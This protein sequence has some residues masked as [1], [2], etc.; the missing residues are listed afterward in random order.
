MSFATQ[1][2]AGARP[3]SV[4]A[5]ALPRREKYHSSPADWREEILYFLLPDRF[6]DAKQRPLL[7]RNNLGTAR[8]LTTGAPWRWDLWCVSG[9]DRWQGGTL[10]GLRSRLGY[11]K[12]LG[13]T[14][15]WVG[16]VFRQRHGQNSYHGYG[17]QDFLEVD[18]HFGTRK[19]LVDLVTSAHQT[20]MRVIL[21]VIFNHSGAN[22]L[23][24]DE[25]PRADTNTEGKYKAR[26]TSG[27]YPFGAWRGPDDNGIAGQ[28]Q[29][30]EDGV[31]PRELQIPDRYTRAG[32]G[33]LDANAQEL[34]DPSAEHK[35][36]DFDVLRDFNL[37]ASGLLSDVAACF[38]Y[39][40][41][42]TDCDGFRL[43]TLK[44]VSIEQARNFCGTIKEFAANLGKQNFLLV[45]EIAGG[46]YNEHRYLDALSLNLDAALDIG[47]MR[48]ALT[49]VA[50]GLAPPL[51]YFG[52]FGS[53]HNF[54]MGSH[55]N[56]GKQH[57]SILDDHDHVFGQKVRFSA[58]AA[59]DHQVVAGVG[60][61]LFSLGIPCVYAGTEQALIGRPPE[62]SEQGFLLN[63]GV[64][65]YYL[66]EAMFGPEHPRKGAAAGVGSSTAALDASLPGFGP[67][68]TAGHHVFDENHPAFKRIAA[69]TAL[70]QKFPVLR[71]GRQYARPISFLGT[72][73]DVYGNGELIAWSRVL[74]DEEALCVVNPHGIERRGGDILVDAGL[75]TGSMTVV[76]NTEQVGNGAFS[77]THAAGS[78]VAVKPR[79]D[80]AVFVEIRD[81]GPSEVLVLTNRP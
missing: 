53:D 8:T 12:K 1:M 67:F 41:A 13:V 24:P 25:T 64:A 26:Y 43:D 62:V 42:L 29:A 45:G 20:G 5:V 2:L 10:A 4:R 16:P 17:L 65:D 35:R 57:V 30:N 77:G 49:A 61:Q 70:R 9:R 7:D 58:N 48:P 74:D 73:F 21:D 37:D 55:R 51:A 40:I 81:V 36:S 79:G 44:H 56:I 46:D 32:T 33:S 68:G 19:D 54:G 52:G 59:S 15:L 39:W 14:A 27:R 28:P 31:W 69:M 47:E 66:R 38:K 72:P 23:Y 60:L 80:G 63:G 18:P 22:W 78:T 11:L 3:D 50:K 76:L 75:S 6:S 34:E 71:A